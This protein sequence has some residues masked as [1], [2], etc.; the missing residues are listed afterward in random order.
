MRPP[1]LGEDQAPWV[2]YT[3]GGLEVENAATQPSSNCSVFTS[4]C[5]L[6][7][8]LCR[9]LHVVYAPRMP[10][11]SRDILSIYTEYLDWYGLLPHPLRSGENSTPAVLFTQ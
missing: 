10:L 8:I 1:I 9:S 11:T 6:S 2:P 4:V 7:V 3:D 5:E